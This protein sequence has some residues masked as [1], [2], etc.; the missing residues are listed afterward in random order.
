MR[1]IGCALFAVMLLVS[2]GCVRKEKHFQSSRTHQTFMPALQ[3]VD[4]RMLVFRQRAEGDSAVFESDRIT[5]VFANLK[6]RERNSFDGE[7][8]PIQIAGGGRSEVVRSCNRNGRTTI[9]RAV[10]KDGVSTITFC[11][12]EVKL[13]DEARK[14]ILGDKEIE[15]VANSERTVFVTTHD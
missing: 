10:Y 4:P 14:V 12:R 13:A 1:Q 3:Q 7:D 6:R 2:G 11:G 15:L 5:L 9:F 8:L